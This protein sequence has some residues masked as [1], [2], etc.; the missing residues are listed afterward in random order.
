MAEV[1][2]HDAG[3]AG[4][5]SRSPSSASAA[6]P[7]AS[8]SHSVP[9][10][11]DAA[12]TIAP[13]GTPGSATSTRRRGTA[14]GCPSCAPEPGCATT[15]RPSTPCRPR[16]GAGCGPSAPTGYDGSPW[17]G[18]A[19]QRRRLR[20]HLRRDHALGR[21]EPAATGHHPLRH[22]VIHDLDRL[23]HGTGQKLDGHFR[24]LA[25]IGLAGADGAQG[26]RARSGR[27]RRGSTISG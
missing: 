20:L 8:C 18:G 12:A 19:P 7:S 27:R 25:D 4:P 26:R 3:S 5:A 6:R 2:A 16:S 11:D 21:A 24:Q 13:P 14:A 23:Y 17:L 22:R 9:R 15:A 10:S 1:G